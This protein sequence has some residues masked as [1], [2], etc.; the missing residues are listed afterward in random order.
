MEAARVLAER[1][2]PVSLYEKETK[3]GGQFAIAAQQPHKEAYASFLEHQQ[4]GLTKARVN[5]MLNTEVTWETIDRDKP[6]ALVIATGATPVVPDIP[7]VN[8]RN[9][10]QAN[11]VITG[12]ARVGDRV[13]VVGGRLVGMEVA[14]ALAE[15]GR[16]VTLTTLHLLGQNGIPSETNIYRTLRN[17]LM[18][19]EVR[20]F[21][22]SPVWEIREDGV[23]IAFHNELV[24]LNADTV[25]LATGA[26]SERKL[27]EELKKAGYYF[28]EI[29]DCVQPRDAMQAVREGAEIGRQI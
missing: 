4:R 23:Y 12:T 24:F 26:K 7:G 9:V 8:C 2:H 20:I 18:D 11:D 1:G 28:F 13:I 19:Q 16:R 22:N 6:G 15:Q 14:L 10:V 17:G 5:V 25:V 21:E 27:G 29:G 3:L